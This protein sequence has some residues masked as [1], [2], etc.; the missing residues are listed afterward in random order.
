[1]FQRKQISAKLTASALKLADI[2][3]RGE[4]I[5]PHLLRI[6]LQV[7]HAP[8]QPINI[9]TQE[10]GLGASLAK[11]RLQLEDACLD[12]FDIG[13]QGNHIQVDAVGDGAVVLELATDVLVLAVAAVDVAIL[14][15][16][17]GPQLEDPRVELV[18][19]VMEIIE[20]RLG[21]GRSGGALDGWAWTGHGERCAGGTGL[22]PLQ[23]GC[24]HGRSVGGCVCV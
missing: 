18:N 15:Q 23:G 2:N 24:G 11:T 9:L 17:S 7:I 21:A 12:L 3:P 5:R 22:T 16:D 8:L 1:M 19:A 20:G 6:L 4:Q 10:D 14:G 13:A